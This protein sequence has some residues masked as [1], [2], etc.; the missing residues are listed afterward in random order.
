MARK[1]GKTFLIAALCLVHLF[2]PEAIDNGE[3]YS[4]AADKDQAATVFKYCRQI[5]EATPWIR[6]LIAGRH[7]NLIETKK[8]IV[9]YP[10]GS[11]Y[12]ALSK[13]AGTKHGQNPTVVICDELAQWKSRELYDVLT[14]GDGA[15]EEFLTLVISTQAA[16][17]SAL[18]SELIDYGLRVNAGEVDDPAFRLWLYAADPKLSPFSRKAWKQANP[19][20][21][22]FLIVRSMEDAAKKAKGMPAAEAQFRNLRLNQRIDAA[23]QFIL[24]AD[25]E[26]NSDPAAPVAGARAWG[27]LDLG[28]TQDLTSLVLIVEGEAHEPGAE[29][30]L[31][32]LPT[33][34]LPEDGLREKA[35]A[36]QFPYDVWHD[37]GFLETTPGRTVNRAF[38]AR[39][40]YE[41]C[42]PYD[43]QGIAYD[44]WRIEELRQRL[45]E[46]GD[47]L[48]LENWGQGFK[49]MSPAIDAF[50]MALKEQILRHGNHPVLRMC[51]AN[52]VATLDPAG[53]RKLD[54]NKARGRID[55]LVALAM[56]LGLRARMSD[57]DRGPS[58]YEERG[59]LEL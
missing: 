30:D 36:D 31:H 15:R 21:D 38:V 41:I 5:C 20:L 25:W 47:G 46:I 49:D 43:L 7:L 33:F 55:G 53:N 39:R 14:S 10:L 1:N 17:D 48:P 50:E 2:G 8:R 40:L 29:P 59:V 6:D 13:E 32:I 3:V 19:A 26:A 42:A 37:Q 35:E 24:P 54:K 9:F 12:V 58:V 45:E 16:N 34:W 51:A 57:N 44:R 22:D 28:A 27:G 52:A 23:A 4:A 56:G 18:L 11:V